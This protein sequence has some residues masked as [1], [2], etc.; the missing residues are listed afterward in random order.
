MLCVWGLCLCFI[1]GVFR[2]S[3]SASVSGTMI[4]LFW[5]LSNCGLLSRRRRR[6]RRIMLIDCA[7]I[8]ST[9]RYLPFGVSPQR[10]WTSWIHGGEQC[11][12]EEEKMEREKES[13]FSEVGGL[14]KLERGGESPSACHKIQQGRKEKCRFSPTHDYPID[15]LQGWK[16]CIFSML[17]VVSYL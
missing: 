9:Y 8:T 17:F 6:R 13:P 12:V 1:P 3:L 14:K 5:E 2:V 10:C 7:W 4:L 15:L 11:G 16:C